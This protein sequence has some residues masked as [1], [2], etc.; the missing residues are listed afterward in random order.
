MSLLPQRDIPTAT[1]IVV[2]FQFFGGAIFLAIAEN[3]FVSKLI[4]LLHI[5]APSVDAKVVVAAGAE[6]LRRVVSVQQLGGALLAYNKA[7]TVTFY[8]GVAG[9]G[10][11][12]FWAF[13]IERGNV[14]GVQNRG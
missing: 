8:L 1:S 9:A 6:G 3:I 14:K 4:S 2:F 5:Y 10:L 13:G 7:I 11:A 12:F